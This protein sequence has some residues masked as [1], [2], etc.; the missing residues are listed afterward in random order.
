M[1]T[2]WLAICSLNKREVG[3]F[4]SR[5]KYGMLELLSKALS[6]YKSQFNLTNCLIF[7]V[8][9]RYGR[10]SWR[11]TLKMTQNKWCFDQKPERHEVCF[12]YWTFLARESLEALHTSPQRL[13]YGGRQ[14][15]RQIIHFKGGWNNRI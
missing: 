3:C 1:A 9:F 10:C 5:V 12:L 4:L 6:V 2:S 8:R 14:E 11:N 13:K 15:T 7:L